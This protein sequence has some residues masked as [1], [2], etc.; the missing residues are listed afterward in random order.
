MFEIQMDAQLFTPADCA[1]YEPPIRQWL[2]ETHP[3]D[4]VGE[5]WF[6]RPEQ[7]RYL[8]GESRSGQETVAGGG[9][10]LASGHAYRVCL[11]LH[12]AFCGCGWCQDEPWR[13][14][15][16]THISWEEPPF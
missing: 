7:L 1:R 13:L 9:L 3:D 14:G 10:T 6:S 4:H 16:M 11:E 12:A 8:P 15:E 2:A 5:I